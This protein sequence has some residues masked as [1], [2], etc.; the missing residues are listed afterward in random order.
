MICSGKAGELLSTMNMGR[1]NMQKM[2]AS[3]LS[4]SGQGL[5]NNYLHDCHVKINLFLRFSIFY[6][7]WKAVNELFCFT[8]DYSVICDYTSILPHL[9]VRAL[10]THLRGPSAPY[11]ITS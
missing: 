7:K 5:Y 3:F 8:K 10:Y 4:P 6:G 11:E 2:N 1:H 9:K